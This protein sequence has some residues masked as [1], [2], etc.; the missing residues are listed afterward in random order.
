MIFKDDLIRIL[1]DNGFEYFV[2]EHAPLFTVEDSK[3]LRGQIEGAHSKNL[4]LKDAKANF[5]LISIEES[6]SIDLK[7]TMQ[8]IQSKKLSF[9]KPEY[10][11]DILGIEPGSVSPFA[12]L[13]DTKKQVKFYLDRSFLDSETVNFHPLI[14]TATVN[15]SP[16]NLIELIEK[17]HNPVNYIDL[18]NLKR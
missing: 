9:A 6:A 17:Y 10:L 1:N 18:E 14:N 8:Q 5:F 11:Q 15:I 3:S 16:Q 13:N 2:E 12:L 4:F 7:K